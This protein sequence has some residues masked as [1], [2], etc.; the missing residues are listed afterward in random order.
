MAGDV[1]Q[2]DLAQ[3]LLAY[4]L[5]QVHWLTTATAARGFPLDRNTAGLSGQIIESQQSRRSGE[6]GG[7]LPCGA[8]RSATAS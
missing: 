7:R 1:D 4:N 2:Q 8:V 5:E 3:Q 6:A